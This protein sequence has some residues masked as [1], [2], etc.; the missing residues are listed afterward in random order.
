MVAAQ[1]RTTLSGSSMGASR[2]QRT[3]ATTTAVGPSGHAVINQIAEVIP[4]ASAERI[5]ASAAGTG[6]A[7]SLQ[8]FFGSLRS[9]P[10]WNAA[11][12]CRSRS[13]VEEIARLSAARTREDILGPAVAG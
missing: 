2:V 7:Q 11:S 10:R 1:A 8:E 6:S 5:P 4:M 3:A 12:H 13:R 9:S